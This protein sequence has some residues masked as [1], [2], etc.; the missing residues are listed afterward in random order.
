DNKYTIV[1]KDLRPEEDEGVYTLK[2][3][4]LILE[5]PSI[6]VVPEEKKPKTETT[7]VEEEEIVTV[8]PHEK[9]PE[10]VVEEVEEVKQIPEEKKPDEIQTSIKEV[11]EGTTVTLTV[12]IPEG[13]SHKMIILLKDKQPVKPSERIKIISTSSTTIEIQIIKA[14]P[15]DS[16]KYS[17]LIDKKE[18][19][20]VQLKVIPKPVTRQIMDIPQTTFNEE[21]TLTIEC[22]FDS[23]PEETFEFLR[24]GK[25]L[26][27]NDRIS[28]IVEDNKYTIVVKN[29]RPKEDEGVYTLK[30]DHLIL[31]TPSITVLPKEKK[32]QT[33][34][35]TVEEEQVT[36]TTV[37]VEEKQRKVQEEEK[38]PK[39]PEEEKQPRVPE[40]EKQ[41]KVPEEEKQ[42][43]VPEED[44]QPRVPEEEKQPKVPQEEKQPRVPEEETQPKVQ[45]E[46]KQPKVLEEEKE[47]KVPEEEKQ[48]RVPEEEKQPKVREE[49][50]QP[51]VP[52]EEKQ[53]KVPE[54]ETQPKVPEE[55]KQ[56]KVQEEEKQPRVPE[57]EAQPKVQ[58][59]EKQPK[60]QEEEIPKN[61]LPVHEVEETT[62]VTF[63]VEQPQTTKP[64]EV[65]LL[66][67]GEEL[68]PSDHVKITPTSPTTTEIQI[69]KVK[70][71][72]EGDYTVKVKDVEQPLVRLKVHP[73]PVIR[74]EIELP[75]IQFN[76][77]ET[78]TIACQFDGT[79]EEP[80]VFL[81]NDEPIVPDSRVTTTVEDNKYTIVVKDL[82]P[83]EDEGVYTLKSDHLILET[84]SITVVPEEKKPKTETTTV[85]EEEIV[86]VVPQEKQPEKVVE[87]VEEVKQIPEEKK[88][89]ETE[90]SIKEVEEGTTV[91]LTVQLPE[92]TS[93]KIII[94]LKDK[95]PVKPS[96][97][98]KIISTSSTTI[99]IQIIKAKPQD[100]GK[101]SVLIDKK[102]QPIVQLKVIPKPV[103][104]QIMD[105]PQTTF[106]EG[107]TLTIEC[108]FDSTP[109]ETFVFLRNGKPLKPNDRISTIVE[110]NKY[111]I[112]V[113]NLRPKE[114]EGVYTLKSDHLILDTPSIT[115]APKEKKPQTETTTVEE[116]EVT[117]T[118]VPVEEKQPKVQESEKQPKVREEEEQ[119]KVQEEE[120]QPKVQDKEKQP[121]VPEEEKQP[122]VPE[123]DK[124]PKVPEEEG[125][126]KVQEEEKQPKVSEQ[127]KQPK[128]PQEEK[129]PKVQ[130]EEMPKKELPVHEVEET[131]TV[132]LTVEQ[133]QTTKP[134]E[135][136]LLKDGEELKP[137]DHVKITPTSPTTTE[138]QITKVKPEDEGDYTVKVKDVEQP[139]V[140]LKVHPKPVIRQEI[141][142]PKIQFNEKETL[143]I[144]CQFDGTPEEPFVFLHNDQPIVPDSRVTTTVE[145]NKYTIVVK[146]LR[147]E[148]DEGV[149]TLK[150]D[151]LIL[152]TPSITVVPE[153]KKPQTETTTVEEEE[154]TVTTVPVEEKQR[155]VHEGEKQPKVP[156]E[157]KQ[158]KVQEEEKQP[159]VPEEEKQPTVP[160][161]EK[162]PK[163]QEEEIP[164]KEL[165]VHE[166]EET[167]TVTLTVEQPQTTKPEE[168]VLLKDGEELKPSDHVKITP[169]SPT[170]TEIQITKVKPE[171]EGEYTGKVK[172]VE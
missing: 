111:T 46:E 71:E 41:S 69:T 15:Q 150:S 151:H 28:T 129:Q 58:E 172:D 99:E 108:E 92:G 37:P 73:K 78:L 136:V 83:E 61:E 80:F 33:E 18:Q 96:E 26:K 45:E 55:E 24:N 29:L 60:V 20:I 9:Q 107:E 89:E 1:V 155:K 17:V 42:P 133:P 164:R 27:P 120:K 168:V 40:E 50:K 57:E 112:V 11:E 67:D 2:S 122:K 138:I 103:T 104:R 158:P 102:E 147:P 54:E 25:S 30:S 39:V 10:K 90:I 70:P 82:R 43:K 68:K 118:T 166:V 84:P 148:E 79:P 159:K 52:E 154:V 56:P 100:T 98:I 113:K 105:I 134:E 72:D 34:T 127:E 115:V 66:K 123:E 59:V 121:K 171:D 95:Q 23:A 88:P 21:E 160:Q 109:E 132:T 156:E 65:V 91:T 128:V 44:V 48:R 97:R 144:A 19:P 62:T 53:S 125:Q 63:T 163:V 77:K 8:V 22:E 165:P 169:T 81:H 140:R 130:E 131:T 126:P 13:T 12:Q 110:D 36:V 124:Q 74:Q 87:E 16:G 75:K 119:P 143:T 32:P 6:T 14:K 7:T 76:E 3:D 170:T 64:E 85:E 157:E 94:L 149:Y 106:N 86:T 35:T 93:H 49:E 153:E 4:H 135:V 152:E 31:D 167:T 101:Y 51:K 47:P 114:D 146:D 117:V 139:L 137:S 161:E 145:D 38:Q 141:Q 142:L 5:T 116:E 162:Q